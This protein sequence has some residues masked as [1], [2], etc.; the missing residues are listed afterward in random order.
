MPPETVIDNAITA[1]E[2]AVTPQAKGLADVLAAKLGITDPVAVGKF[3]AWAVLTVDVAGDV[4]AAKAG[5]ALNA[6]LTWVMAKVFGT[7]AA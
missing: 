5:P 4:V 1:V 3:E 7:K 2:N 6:G